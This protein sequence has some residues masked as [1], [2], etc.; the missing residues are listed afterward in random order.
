MSI[1]PRDPRATRPDRPDVRRSG[2]H[3][4]RSVR[5]RTPGGTFFEGSF[6]E[7]SDLLVL[8]RLKEMPGER[9]GLVLNSSSPSSRQISNQT[10]NTPPRALSLPPLPSTDLPGPCPGRSATRT[11]WLSTHSSLLL[12]AH[13]LPLAQSR[14]PPCLGPSFLPPCGRVAPPPPRSA[15]PS[16]RQPKSRPT[17]SPQEGIASRACERLRTDTF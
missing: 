7:S 3:G 12:T 13:H 10:V 14:S 2:P 11:R 8:S 15:A 5:N 6:F 16:S 9:D 4:L 17:R 1:T